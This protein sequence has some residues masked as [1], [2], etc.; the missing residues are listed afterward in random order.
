MDRKEGIERYLKAHD[1][2]YDIALNEIATGQKKTHWMWFIFPQIAGLGRSATAKYYEIQNIDEAKAYW[3]HPV[4]SSHLIEITQAFLDSGKD[5][6]S[7]FGYIDS[8]KLRSCM[9]LFWE[10]S[11]EPIFREVIQ[12]YY[13]G[14]LDGFTLAAFTTE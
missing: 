13:G 14:G 6:H 10:I 4:L 5:P 7:V 8:L 2:Y 9:T 12:K 3:G 1:Q 11:K